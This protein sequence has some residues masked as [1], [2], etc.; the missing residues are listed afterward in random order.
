MPGIYPQLMLSMFPTLPTDPTATPVV[1]AQQ[2]QQIYHRCL[3]VLLLILEECARRGIRVNHRSPSFTLR[4]RGMGPQ[5]RYMPSIC[6]VYA[7]HIPGIAGD[8][9]VSVANMPGNMPSICLVYAS[10]SHGA[11]GRHMPMQ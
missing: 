7:R 5:I 1:N 6:L 11:Y 4:G 9:F 10:T 3:A 2:R 8:V